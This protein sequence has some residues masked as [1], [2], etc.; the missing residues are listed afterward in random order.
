MNVFRLVVVDAVVGGQALHAH[1]VQQLAHVLRLV[2]GPAVVRS[3]ELHVLIP[4]FG[5]F[6]DGPHQVL[7][8]RLADREELQANRKLVELG[9]QRKGSAERGC[10]KS[11]LQEVAAIHWSYRTSKAQQ[12]H[13]RYSGGE[14][15]L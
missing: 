9:V 8:Q 12:Y 4:Q 14:C 7:G 15:F 5:H 13:D 11:S 6:P 10:T 2:E 1:V 3:E